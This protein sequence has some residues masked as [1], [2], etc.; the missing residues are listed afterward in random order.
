M[1]SDREYPTPGSQIGSTLN[2]PRCGEILRYRQI[3]VT[4]GSLKCEGFK[5]GQQIFTTGIYYSVVDLTEPQTTR[6]ELFCQCGYAFETTVFHDVKW[7]SY[8][9]RGKILVDTRDQK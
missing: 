4:E 7:A 2:C 9:D 5:R 8:E 1:K 6:R 3:D